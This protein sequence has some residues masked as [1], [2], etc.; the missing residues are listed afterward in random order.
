MIR[1]SVPNKHDGKNLRQ[2]SVE[3]F[4]NFVNFGLPKAVVEKRSL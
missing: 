3:V 1:V 4:I 2:G